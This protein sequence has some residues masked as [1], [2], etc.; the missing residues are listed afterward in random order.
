VPDGP[1]PSSSMWPP[2]LLTLSVG[3]SAEGSLG[4][5][6]STGNRDTSAVDRCVDAGDK[7]VGDGSGSGNRC[8]L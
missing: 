7:S 4:T 5:L 3:L 1:A 2:H 6:C 8:T